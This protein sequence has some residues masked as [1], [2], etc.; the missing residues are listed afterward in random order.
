VTIGTRTSSNTQQFRTSYTASGIAASYESGGRTIF[1]ES[2]L[3]SIPGFLHRY[4]VRFG[5]DPLHGFIWRNAAGLILRNAAGV[6]LRGD[7][8]PEEQET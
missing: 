7:Y 2:G 8:N 6:I 5:T 1:S 3:D 4:A